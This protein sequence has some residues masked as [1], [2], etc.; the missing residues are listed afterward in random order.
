[1][2]L[3]EVFESLDLKNSELLIVGNIENKILK[4]IKKYKS[5]K[6]IVFKNA[7]KQSELKKFYN[8]SNIFVTCSIE[9]G[10]SM[11]Q[12]Q[13]MACGLPVICTINSGGQEIIDD[14]IDGYILPIRN[15]SSLKEKILFL[16]NNKLFCEEMGKN[17]QK[18]VTKKFSWEMYGQKTISIYQELLKQ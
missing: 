2:Y 17:A 15:K 9:E 4:K 5:N 11:V 18:K 10:L 7:V 14:N 12:L 1:M 3:L 13:A 6:K 8:I 16:Y